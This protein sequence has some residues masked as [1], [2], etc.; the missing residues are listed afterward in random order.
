MELPADD[1][2]LTM[3]FQPL[4][5]AELPKYLAMKLA[6]LALKQRTNL[7]DHHIAAAFI[8]VGMQMA[9]YAHGAATAAEWLRDVAD[10][11]ENGTPK[12]GHTN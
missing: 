9:V 1:Q 11:I 12:K 4:T 7:A 2:S 8:S 10:E 6:E 3:T 5:E